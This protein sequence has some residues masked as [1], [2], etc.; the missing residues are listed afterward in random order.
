AE[1]LAD[2]IRR[3]L[4]RMPVLAR[5][6]SAAYRARKFVVR[7]WVPVTAVALT[8]ASLAA[9]VILALRQAEIAE[10]MRLRAEEERGRAL[11][12]MQEA[13][14]QRGVAQR[15]ATEALA[16][17][18]RADERFHQVRTLIQRFLFDIDRAVA[19]VP[20]TSAAR[21]VVANTALEYLDSMT[22][23]GLPDRGILRDLA[24]AYERVAELQGSPVRP[25]LNDFPAA[26][27]S[28]QKALRIRREL[29]IDSPVARSE[30]MM[31]HGNMGVV[32]RNMDKRPESAAAFEEGL[33]LFT[34]PDAAHADVRL[35]A[36]NLF[37]QRA[38]LRYVQSLSKDAIAD[39][40]RAERLLAQ[41][42]GEQPENMPAARSLGLIRMHLGDH[43]CRASNYPAGLPFLRLSVEQMRKLTRLEP[44]N[45]AHMRSLGMALRALSSAYLDR[46]AG[47]HRNTAEA[48]RLA[49]EQVEVS[50]RVAEQDKGNHTAERDYTRAVAALGR[51][52]ASRDEWEPAIR[53]YSQA[54]AMTEASSHVEEAA[55]QFD[56][57]YYCAELATAEYYLKNY[58]RSLAMGRRSV[59]IFEAAIARGSKNRFHH[60]NIALIVRRFGDIA[61]VKGDRESARREYQRA[62]DIFTSLQK[63][64]P[65]VQM[66]GF[67]VKMTEDAMAKLR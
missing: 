8:I 61:L 35:S 56:I 33:R 12:A 66:F 26:I 38:E 5:G 47:E 37:S 6:N 9:G 44:N 29:G 7:N 50:K 42:T 31:L 34:G 32:Y 11:R 53:Y 51:A 17:K 39:Y 30:R 22:K 65:K 27:E 58:E 20:G 48:L 19:D 4:D 59:G 28:Y 46:A 57:A 36:A 45:M 10:R 60:F 15:N 52:H 3:H 25:S 63:D 43:L 24:V 16:Q 55:S 18:G 23:D 67:Q 41:V 2:D 62:M 1:Q 13:T 64:D 14:E 49:G 40:E 54:L 21:R